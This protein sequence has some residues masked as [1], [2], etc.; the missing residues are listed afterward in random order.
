MAQRGDKV[1][2]MAE[3]SPRSQALTGQNKQQIR[4]INISDKMS[5]QYL[6][7]F[8]PYMYQIW[9]IGLDSERH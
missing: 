2:E 8:F 9:Y 1:G 4:E 7:L 3:N 5:D 6:F